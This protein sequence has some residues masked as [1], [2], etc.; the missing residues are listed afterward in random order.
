MIG[1]YWN[2][3]FP[4]EGA[5]M[6][7]T[8]THQEILDNNKVQQNEALGEYNRYFAN[9]HFGR[10]ATDSECMLYYIKTAALKGTVIV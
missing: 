5:A 9:R 4:K 2:W 7:Q 3:I 6:C 8:S 10:V 1:I